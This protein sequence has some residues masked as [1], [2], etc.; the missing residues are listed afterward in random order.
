[1]TSKIFCSQPLARLITLAD[2][3]ALLD[4]REKATLM[5]VALCIAESFS[6]EYFKGD[7]DRTLDAIRDCF[8]S[9]FENI[10]KIKEAE[11]KLSYTVQFLGACL[12]NDGMPIR[13]E[14]A[15]LVKAMLVCAEANSDIAVGDV[16]R[17]FIDIDRYLSES[18]AQNLDCIDSS[19]EIG[20]NKYSIEYTH[21]IGYLNRHTENIMYSCLMQ[22]NVDEAFKSMV[23][24]FC[25][26]ST[27]TATPMYR[28]GSIRRSFESNM[29]KNETSSA[30]LAQH[31]A[32]L[33]GV[34][35]FE[36]AIITESFR[37]KPIGTFK[38]TGVLEGDTLSVT[39]YTD[40]L[41]KA[42]FVSSSRV[43]DYTDRIVK[44]P[45]DTTRVLNLFG[46]DIGK[47][48]KQASTNDDN[49]KKKNIINFEGL[50]KIIDND[51]LVPWSKSPKINVN[52]TMIN[53]VLSVLTKRNQRNAVILGS[54]GSGRRTLARV[55]SRYPVFSDCITYEIDCEAAS[56]FNVGAAHV[57]SNIMEVLTARNDELFIIFTDVK[58]KGGVEVM[59]LVL[60]KYFNRP[61]IHT[62]MTCSDMDDLENGIKEASTILVHTEPSTKEVYEMF[63]DNLDDISRYYGVKFS[64]KS[65]KCII[66][67]LKN[68]GMDLPSTIHGVIDNLSARIR[69]NKK[70]NKDGL[71]LITA[72]EL[73]KTFIDLYGEFELG[74]VENTSYEDNY[75]AIAKL[76]KNLKQRVYGQDRAC[77]IVDKCLK[78][79]SVGLND[80]NK[81]VCNLM[82]VGPTGVGKT[83]LAKAIADTLN[84]PLIRYNMTEYQ[85]Q[86]SVNK[87]IGSAPGYVGADRGGKLVNDI[88]ENPKCVLLLDEIEKA[89][90]YV[91]NTLLNIMDDAKLSDNLGNTADFTNVILIMTSNAG[92]RDIGSRKIGFSSSEEDSIVKDEAMDAAI[93]ETFS[94]EFINR[95]T[96]IVKFNFL[97][98]DSGIK[99]INKKI[100][101]LKEKLS[102]KNA[103]VEFSDD[104]I[105]LMLKRG[106]NKDFGAREINRIFLKEIKADIAEFIINNRSNNKLNLKIDTDGKVFK[107]T[108]SSLKEKAIGNS[109]S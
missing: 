103:T 76:S 54:K 18:E 107:V 88:I 67:V 72:A 89:H 21:T 25:F 95:I 19:V 40:I 102:S 84:I 22:N 106:I 74:E 2:Y 80:E 105:E 109:N 32:E 1:M 23:N 99:I 96:E 93:K 94:P 38:E 108:K 68:Y 16:L 82:F 100:K 64:K 41:K 69:L 92:A 17:H 83:E 29:K 8:E 104:T 12:V 10:K 7:K 15:H 31:L 91:Y 55:I 53:N 46:I 60:Q 48:A 97:N 36:S 50:V 3:K 4:G 86:I 9:V 90:P 30:T 81:T 77:D 85:D 14:I 52:D 49:K 5:D 79:S 42:I 11:F 58:N 51:N 73:T 20:D 70:A 45:D 66:N 13:C 63:C 35:A 39:E 34:I 71:V 87:L 78:V 24:D 62:I 65:I 56:R 57:L 28:I 44:G 98:R 33:C 101:E 59:S 61:N 26:K 47:V 75:S 37:V 6:P 43:P 27:Y